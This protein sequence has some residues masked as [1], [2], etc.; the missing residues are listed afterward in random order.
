M[1]R[2]DRYHRMHDSEMETL[3][4]E[5][6]GRRGIQRLATIDPVEQS[7]IYGTTRRRI[8]GQIIQLLNIGKSYLE[9]LETKFSASVD[10]TK[11]GQREIDGVLEGA[12]AMEDLKAEYLTVSSELKTYIDTISLD[13]A[14]DLA[15]LEDLVRHVFVIIETLIAKVEGDDAFVRAATD[16][17][18]A[19]LADAQIQLER[20]AT[21]GGKRK[22]SKRKT[23]RKKR[24]NSKKKKKKRKTRKKR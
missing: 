22:K 18:A 7:R 10:V 13:T 9:E 16:G 3:K 6:L 14:E 12:S 8:R 2:G 19:E 23:R 17:K 4:R 20:A 1:E 5:L 21:I 24:K 15:G 11:L